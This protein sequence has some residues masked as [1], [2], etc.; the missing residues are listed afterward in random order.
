L[1]AGAIAVITGAGQ[2][3]GR[4]ITLGLAAAGARVVATD[5]DE[6]LAG[7]TARL[8]REQG[9]SAWSYRLDVT[10]PGCCQRVADACARGI[11]DTSIL[12]NNAGIIVRERMDSPAAAAAWR[13]VHDVNLDGVFN[14]SRAWLGALRVTRGAIVNVASIAAFS[15]IAGAVGYSSSK[16]AVRLLT[17]AMARELAQDGIRVNAIAPGVIDTPMTAATREN[18]ER[19]APFM[20]RTPMARVGQPVELVGPV[21]FLASSMASYVTGVILPVDGGYLAA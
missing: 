10:D 16:G 12:V 7:D 8:V 21:V 19:L 3:N 15:G 9:G 6:T 1:L 17:Q 18:P 11:G 20:A 14:A 5:L 4:A 2:G 13:R